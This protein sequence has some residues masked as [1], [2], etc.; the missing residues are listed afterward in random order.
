MTV[1][2]F[3]TKLVGLL[4]ID[5]QLKPPYVRTKVVT[6][7]SRGFMIIRV[8]DTEVIRHARF[9]LGFNRPMIKAP[10]QKGR[11]SDSSGYRGCYYSE[12]MIIRVYDTVIRHTRYR[13]GLNPQR[14]R[15]D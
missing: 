5:Q 8:N 3:V 13:F 6:L 7:P 15:P 4:Q 10:L 11:N 12:L 9:R 1:L 2:L 14:I